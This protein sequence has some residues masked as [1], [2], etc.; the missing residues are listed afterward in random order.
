MKQV[1]IGIIFI[2]LRCSADAPCFSDYWELICVVLVEIMCPEA[3]KGEL[4]EF[5]PV[6]SYFSNIQI[7][8]TFRQ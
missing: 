5:E 4:L 1:T 2:W 8:S 6:L 7:Q 3:V